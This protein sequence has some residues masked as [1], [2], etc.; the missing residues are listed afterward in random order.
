MHQPVNLPQG[1]KHTI[2]LLKCIGE[3][4]YPDE[5]IYKIYKYTVASV[6]V[7]TFILSTLYTFL[8][9]D[10]PE[11]AKI[12]YYIPSMTIVPIKHV[13]FRTNFPKILKLMYILE[14]QHDQIRRE[15][16]KN[17]VNKSTLL[18]RNLLKYYIALFLF[19][20][21]G[22]I[23]NPLINQEK[24][25]PILVWLPFD[26]H[27]PVIFETVFFYFSVTAVYFSC[28]NLLTDL[29]FYNS[30][31][32][33]ETQ[34][35]LISDTFRHLQT[36][37]ASGS[38]VVRAGIDKSSGMHRILVECINQYKVTHDFTQILVDCYKEILMVQFAC[39]FLSIIMTM[40][41]LSMAEAMSSDF[42]RL[43]FFQMA[44]T[45]E[46]FLYCYF[47][48]RT[49]EKSE[50][51][52]YASYES[53]WYNTSKELKKDLL[54][55][56]EQLKNP[57]VLFVWNIFPLNYKTFKAIMQKSWSFYMALKNTSEMRGNKK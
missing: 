22:V 31:I 11:V 17:I 25:L 47:G 35:D 53:I 28:V 4:C 54:I 29:F 27:Q 3:W 7:S 23:G 5:H 15:E 50:L 34:C 52:Y 19:A 9:L 45:G 48:N 39:S 42:F 8:N 36:I 14:S 44:A 33:V 26:Y 21:I 6:L 38:D 56:M 46:I 51:L 2:F 32:H 55:F 30:M 1:L 13:L 12:T 37:S 18:A 24:S 20:I 49:I 10:D 57:I 16:Q 40:N 43:I 41:Q